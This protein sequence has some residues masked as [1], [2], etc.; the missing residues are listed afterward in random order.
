MTVFIE[1]GVALFEV[2]V[3]QLA[4][5]LGGIDAAFGGFSRAEKNDWV[6]AIVTYAPFQ[7]FR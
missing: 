3:A 2:C 6:V 7:V 1:D 5:E 4:A